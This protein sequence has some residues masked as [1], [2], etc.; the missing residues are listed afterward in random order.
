MITT[1][2]NPEDCYDYLIS[3]FCFSF[4]LISGIYQIVSTIVLLLQV[5]TRTAF[6]N[7]APK[8]NLNIPVIH[9]PNF[10]MN[11]NVTQ[12]G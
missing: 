7:I 1:D 6:E 10:E 8:N 3:C 2:L 12:I 11:L 4:Y 5:N 9:A